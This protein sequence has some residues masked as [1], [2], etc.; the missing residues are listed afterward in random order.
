MLQGNPFIHHQ[1]GSFT[2]VGMPLAREKG[3]HL[4][5]RTTKLCNLRNGRNSITAPTVNQ[6]RDSLL[7]TKDAAV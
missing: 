1:W 7:S 2:N 6:I 3:N 5:T 4:P